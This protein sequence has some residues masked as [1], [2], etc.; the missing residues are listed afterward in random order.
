MNDTNPLGSGW[1]DVDVKFVG[2]PE[3]AAPTVNEARG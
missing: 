3:L 1:N 2:A